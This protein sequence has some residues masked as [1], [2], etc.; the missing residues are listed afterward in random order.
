MKNIYISMSLNDMYGHM[1]HSLLQHKCLKTNHIDG[2]S[3]SMFIF[4]LIEYYYYVAICRYLQ[5]SMIRPHLNHSIQNK[6]AIHYQLFFVSFAAHHS[7]RFE[8]IRIIVSIFVVFFACNYCTRPDFDILDSFE[9]EADEEQ[10]TTIV[11]F[12]CIVH[13]ESPAKPNHRHT[14]SLKTDMV[15]VR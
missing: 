4:I 12:L 1:S 13:S 10:P 8:Q 6:M 15:T 14:S 9:I 5:K 3:M 7:K 2:P 11:E